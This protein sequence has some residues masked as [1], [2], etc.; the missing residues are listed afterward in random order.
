MSHGSVIV[1]D[2]SDNIKEKYGVGFH[3]IIENQAG[4]PIEI[5]DNLVLNF[6]GFTKPATI[7]SDSNDR[8][9]TYFI[10]NANKLAIGYL[11]ER[12]E[13]SFPDVLIAVEVES[14]EDAYLKI[15]DQENSDA[16]PDPLDFET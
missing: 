3:L 9:R 15:V 10:P 6:G 4:L 5:L 16:V 8:R 14:L 11:I 2:T 7:S 1:L 13:E 12:V